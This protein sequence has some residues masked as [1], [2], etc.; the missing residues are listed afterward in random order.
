MLSRTELRKMVPDIIEVALEGGDW[1]QRYLQGTLSAR[2]AQL[3]DALGFS[4]GEAASPS[5]I[6]AL[7]AYTLHALDEA[8]T[9]MGVTLSGGAAP[10]PDERKAPSG[11]KRAPPSGPKRAAK[12]LTEEEV[13]E[14]L[15][16]LIAAFLDYWRRTHGDLGGA[17]V[18]R[19]STYGR[20][21]KHQRSLW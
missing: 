10:N 18:E 4:L 9:E 6:E 20:Y 17:A 21:A 16:A 15:P 3:A 8:I 11:P 1:L 2:R 13:L 12:E 5:E 19:F 14:M 7:V